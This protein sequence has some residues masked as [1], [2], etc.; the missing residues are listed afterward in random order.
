MSLDPYLNFDGDC[1]AA[2]DFYKQ[3]FGGEFTAEMTFADGPEGV[4]V[5]EGD[6]DKIMH[7]SLPIGDSI[8]M[9]SD[10]PSDQSPVT[11]GSNVHIS[12][13]P[14][15][16]EVAKERFARL[17]EGGTVTMPLEEQFW[18]DFFGSCTDRFGVHW[19]INLT[20]G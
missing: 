5:A 12:H 9:G 1:R 10:V 11:S 8:L 18:G 17:S 13:A 7:V 6:K 4:P 20:P 16:V 14:P 3:V 15:S 2:F 19:M